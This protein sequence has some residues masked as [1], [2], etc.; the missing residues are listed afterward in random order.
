MVRLKTWAPVLN[1]FKRVGCA[2]PRSGGQPEISLDEP[3]KV[4]FKAWLRV[5]HYLLRHRS[6]SDPG[7]PPD[8]PAQNCAPISAGNQTRNL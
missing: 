4:V 7:S 2:S 3:G 6:E 8:F 1:R 5:G